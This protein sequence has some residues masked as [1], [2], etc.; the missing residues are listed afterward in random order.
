MKPL[1]VLLV[2]FV[3]ALLVMKLALNNFDLTLSGRI[4]MAVMLA[5]TAIGHFAFTKGMVMMI[6][7]FIP[8]KKGLVYFTGAIEIAAA[9]GLLIP[10]L[11]VLTAWLLILFFILLLPANIS[12][13]IRHVDYQKGTFE[14]SGVIY[15]WF[16]VPLQ[17]LFILWTY[18][19]AIRF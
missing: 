13:A 19:S 1:I 18:V 9:A 4:A 6:P 16:R 12:A 5:F 2:S 8:F 14:G 3:I 17:L 10:A 7:D 11:Q 15:L